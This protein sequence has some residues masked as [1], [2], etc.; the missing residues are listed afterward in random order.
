VRLTRVSLY[1]TTGS[2]QNLHSKYH[3]FVGH[4]TFETE[5]AHLPYDDKLHAMRQP[6]MRQR[7]LSEQSFFADKPFAQVR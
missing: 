3:P 7:L 6:E 5:L 2:L 1:H 4:P